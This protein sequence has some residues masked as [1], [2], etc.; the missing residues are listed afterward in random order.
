MGRDR[1][2]VGVEPVTAIGFLPDGFKSS[3]ADFLWL[4]G[5]A[6]TMSAL[7]SKTPVGKFV[8]WLWRRNVSDPAGQW[9]RHQIESTVDPMLAAVK[10]EVMAASRAQHEEQNEKLDHATAQRAAI[11]D[12]LDRLEARDP[13]A[14][15]RAEDRKAGR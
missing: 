13:K 3:G 12:R 5:V 2:P 15:T 6:L 10:A 7:W 8:R 4:V 9:A 1:L 14:R 11:H